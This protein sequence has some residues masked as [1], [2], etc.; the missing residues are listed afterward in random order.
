MSAHNQSFR[1]KLPEPQPLVEPMPWW[2][3]ALCLAVTCAV[4][5]VAVAV[6]FIAAVRVL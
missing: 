3:I 1:V 5:W 4:C 6:L 2:R